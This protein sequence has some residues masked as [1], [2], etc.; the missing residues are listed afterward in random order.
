MP[1]HLFTHAIW[2]SLQIYIIYTNEVLINQG[3]NNE[4]KYR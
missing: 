2:N 4:H 3:L 1:P